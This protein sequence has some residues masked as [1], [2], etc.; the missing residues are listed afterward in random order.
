M[1]QSGNNTSKSENSGEIAD[2]ED[3]VLKEFNLWLH[4]M[5]LSKEGSVELSSPVDGFLNILLLKNSE[6]C[7]CPY[8]INQS[9]HVIRGGQNMIHTINN[10]DIFEWKNI[11]AHNVGLIIF[12]PHGYLNDFDLKFQQNSARFKNGLLTSSDNRMHLLQTQLLELYQKPTLLNELKIQSNL[13]EI[14]AHQIDG[15]LVEN[16]NQKVI[17]IKSHYDKIMLAKKMIDS[18][19]SKNFTISELAK[20][21]G[22]NEQYLK[23]YF[24]GYFGKTV[25][26]YITDRKMTYAKELIVSGN[27][28]VAD[29]ARMTGYKHSTHFTTA[30]KKYFGFIPNS[31][32]YTYMLAHG[33]GEILSEFE[34][35][36]NIL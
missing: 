6:N 17:A 3:T 14:I 25:L 19:L 1:T 16:E 7:I 34:S 4:Y 31:L 27:Y 23:K 35:F 2:R 9:S 30:F 13:I 32:R 21:V 33:A 12:I 24:K 15:L 28:R 29:V 20:Q 11:Y 8:F 22:T 18:D 10:G 5:L 36:I 26:N